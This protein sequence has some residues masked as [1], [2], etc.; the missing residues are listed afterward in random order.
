MAY[1]APVVAGIMHR[2]RGKWLAGGNRDAVALALGTVYQPRSDNLLPDAH[3]GHLRHQ[4]NLSRLFGQRHSWICEVFRRKWS[5]PACWPF[6]LTSSSLWA[7]RNTENIPHVDRLN[8]P[9]HRKSKQTGLDNDYITDWSYGI[10]ESWTFLVPN[11][12]G[13]VSGQIGALNKE[14]LKDVEPNYKQYVGGRF[15]SYFGDQPFTMGPVV[16]RCP[17]MP[18]L[19]PGSHP[20]ERPAEVVALIGYSASFMLSWGKYFMGFS[21]IFLDYVPGYDKFRAVA[22]TL[23]HRGIHRAADGRRAPRPHRQRSRRLYSRQPEKNYLDRGC[24]GRLTL[25]ILYLAFH[26]LLL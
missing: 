2:Y 26:V 12:K 24:P 6:C 14:A 9:L 16:R 19:P 7:T 4:W 23:V 18:A 1:M 3:D 22:M 25:Y 13:G 15:T 10:G 5:L 21:D 17:G 8:S 20:G 11:F